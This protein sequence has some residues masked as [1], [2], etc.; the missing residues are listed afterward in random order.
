M[1]SV[2]KEKGVNVEVVVQLGCGFDKSCMNQ[3][4]GAQVNILFIFEAKILLIDFNV[5]IQ[6]KLG[7]FQLPRCS[8]SN[9]NPRV[10]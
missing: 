7:V 10:P 1:W 5:L 6:P 9:W 3:K 8:N 4:Y 2:C